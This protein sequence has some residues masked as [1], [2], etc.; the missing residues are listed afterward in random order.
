MESL[1]VTFLLAS[2]L[3]C[4]WLGVQIGSGRSDQRRRRELAELERRFKSWMAGP[5]PALRAYLHCAKGAN[6]LHFKGIRVF[7]HVRVGDAAAS[8]PRRL[9]VSDPD[10]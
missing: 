7:S 10:T 6:L 1:V 9:R 5:P 2:W 3:G 4:F 8:Q